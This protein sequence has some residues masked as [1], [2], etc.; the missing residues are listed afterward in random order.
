M[1]SSVDL[2]SSDN[3]LGTWS[4][5]A[6]SYGGFSDYSVPPSEWL[7]TFP[8]ELESSPLGYESE[9]GAKDLPYGSVQGGGG[10]Y[11]RV[12]PIEVAE[13]DSTQQG[14]LYASAMMHHGTSGG[15]MHGFKQQP[16]VVMPV[17]YVSHG[18][19]PSN[20]L[21]T[22]GAPT[23]TQSS[24]YPSPPGS[25]PKIE[26]AVNHNLP[27][28][29]YMNAEHV[30]SPM[31][32]GRRNTDST[33]MAVSGGGQYGSHQ[34]TTDLYQPYAIQSSSYEETVVSGATGSPASSIDTLP[35][36]TPKYEAWPPVGHG[37][38]PLGHLSANG[39]HEYFANY[40]PSSSIAAGSSIKAELL[41][42]TSQ[43]PPPLIKQ[44][45][46]T[47]EQRCPLP[48]LEAAYEMAPENRIEGAMHQEDQFN[49]KTPPSRKAPRI[50][51]DM[52][53]RFV[54]PE[55][56]R[57]FARQCGLT[58]HIKWNHSGT[59]PFRCFTCGKCFADEDTLA[60]H[61]ERH[62]STDKPFQCAV[63]PKA[64]F[65]KNDLRRHMYQ[66]TGTAPHVCKYCGKTFA[67]KDHCHAH[68]YSHERKAQRRSVKK[69]K[70]DHTGE[71]LMTVSAASSP[72]TARPLSED[73]GPPMIR[74][75]D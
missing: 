69:G 19:Y 60:A 29:V 17:H 25:V 44:E 1:Q 2:V 14:G 47:S 42:D 24:I 50:T 28:V 21:A 67:R 58:Q 5:N 33:P 18:F 12:P 9:L 54:C 61:M 22:S 71:Q 46:S 72:A 11:Q 30:G 68:E 55:C 51:A 38:D 4:N 8:T 57:T 43:S 36:I 49:P 75:C 10:S 3:P 20:G 26:S 45:Y 73:C 66:H 53:Q 52:G 62:T 27:Y 35:P 41:S 32:Y 59:K 48:P 70:T 37:S 31:A 16:P 39:K 64:F 63:C 56:S 65:H 6:F 15:P 34:P 7:S 40:S 13:A 74:K 23:L